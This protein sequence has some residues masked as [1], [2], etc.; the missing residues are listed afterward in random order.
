MVLSGE[1]VMMVRGLQVVL[2]S[3]VTLLA[4]AVKVEMVVMLLVLVRQVLPKHKL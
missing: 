3:L 4:V 1:T 2:L